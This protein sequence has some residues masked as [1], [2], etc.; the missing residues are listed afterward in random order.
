VTAEAKRKTKVARKSGTNAMKRK[1]ELIDLRTN[2]CFVSLR[3][4]KSKANCNKGFCSVAKRKTSGKEEG[5]ERDEEEEGGDRLAQQRQ[6]CF[7]KQ[8]KVKSELQRL[9]AEGNQ[10]NGE[11]DQGLTAQERADGAT[12]NDI[13]RKAKNPCVA[14]TA[15][16]WRRKAK[17]WAKEATRKRRT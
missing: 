13:F 1:R 3:K 7:A 10:T 4:E 16:T 14:R 6:F 8:I 11:E 9:R 2:D 15:S 12:P 5:N 17:E